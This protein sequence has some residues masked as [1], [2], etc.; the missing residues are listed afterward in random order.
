LQ[1]EV[2]HSP[3][4]SN[5]PKHHLRAP[6]L[7][8]SDPT[9]AHQYLPIP[10]NSAKLRL[11]SSPPSTSHGNPP[12]G[13]G[14][15][16]PLNH[17]LAESELDPYFNAYEASTR[18]YEALLTGSIER[19]NRRIL[20]RLQELSLDY[21][22][23]GARYNA[24]S[25]SES[26]D[27]ASAIERVGQAVDSSYIQTEELARVL[28]SGFAEP[29]RESAQFAGVVQ[30][31]LRYRVMK[32]IQE[33]QTRDLLSQKRQL[34][35]SLEKSE[36]EARRIEHYLHANS[37]PSKAAGGD[38][39]G[40]SSK[41]DD[42][43]SLDSV[44]LPFPP[45]HSETSPPPPQRRRSATSRALPSTAVHKKS[46]SFSAGPSSS[47]NIF[48]KGFGKLNYAIHGIVDVDPERT[49]R[50]NIGK[51]REV[52]IQLEGAEKAVEK[53]VE[54]AGRAVLKD[55]RRFQAEKVKD[56]KQVMREY[57]KV[58]IEWAKRCQEAWEEAGREVGKI[59]TR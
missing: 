11:G 53:D 49:R 22:E 40:G 29:L 41:A 6:P 10:S 26:G 32:R 44:D 56:M 19:V 34:L 28:G 2:L 8:P 45:T 54:E 17:N 36:M 30:K 58:H 46:S 20:K 3:P 31:V 42:V 50:D 13:F 27:L 57:A 14:R 47:S 33:D 15:F 7:N 43:E 21:N 25:L 48:A 35:E 4:I 39:S 59:S 9:A 23:L 51:T 1:S 55:L 38:T 16:P 52:L 12:G 18:T 24:F 37:Q 5:L